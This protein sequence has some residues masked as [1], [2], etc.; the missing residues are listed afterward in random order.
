MMMV[1][2]GRPAEDRLEGRRASSETECIPPNLTGLRDEEFLPLP[3]QTTRGNQSETHQLKQE[4]IAFHGWSSG[5]WV[6]TLQSKEISALAVKRVLS[7]GAQPREAA[8]LSAAL[9][10]W[11]VERQRTGVND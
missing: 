10:S 4:E 1:G 6:A 11:Q 7:E 5:Y 3:A 2:L 8:S 9:Q